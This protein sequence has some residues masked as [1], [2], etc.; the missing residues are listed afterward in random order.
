MSLP[1]VICMYQHILSYFVTELRFLY[2]NHG[3][4]CIKPHIHWKLDYT[5]NW[6]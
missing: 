5:Y 1:Y 4:V 2:S 3:R 6:Q